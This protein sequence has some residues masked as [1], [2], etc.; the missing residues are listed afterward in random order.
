Q[1]VTEDHGLWQGSVLSR[2]DAFFTADGTGVRF[3]EYNGETP[4]GAAYGDVLTEL[5]HAMPV[6]RDYQRHWRTTALPARHHTVN[7]LLDGFAE[8]R[9]SREAPR[10]VILDWKDVPTYHEFVLFRQYFEG[11]GIEC[12]I[13]DPRDCE[14]QGGVLYADGNPVTLIYKRVLISELL[15]RGGGLDQPVVRAVRDRA[16]CLMDGFR[17]KML[18]KKASL[19]VLHDERNAHLFSAGELAAIRETVPFTRV[20]EERKTEV[21]GQ[22][23]D[24]IPWIH[25]HRER[26][27]L[28]PN[29]EYGGAGIVLGWEESDTQWEAA[30]GTALAT[31]HVVQ[32]RI[33]LPSEPFPS[34]VDGKLVI[35]NRIVD[36]APFCFGGTYTDGCLSRI[37]TATLV[38]VT[39]GGGSTVPTFIVESR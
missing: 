6:M 35:A 26:L 16:A 3:T 1:R 13:A 12:V 5:F 25:A 15:E 21:D 28:K 36:T 17:C 37:S 20:V 7:A 32:E 34:S 8:W 31:P 4:A 2:L 30:V 11:L 33:H 9:G 18:H 39:A 22:P 29:D 27:V 38:N 23:V 10:V 14:Y 19:A 24:L